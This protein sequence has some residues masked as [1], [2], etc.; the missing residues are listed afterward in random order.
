MYME[1]REIIKASKPSSTDISSY[2][3]QQK[4][5]WALVV[6]ELQPYIN[7]GLD[8][9]L[10]T[11]EKIREAIPLNKD[12]EYEFNLDLR[13]VGNEHRNKAYQQLEKFL[14]IKMYLF[15]G[16]DREQTFNI[17]SSIQR[18][19]EYVKVTM[20]LKSLRW[21]LDFGKKQ[22]FVSF[23]KPSFLKL[24][25]GY[26]MNLFLLLSENYNRGSF[27]VSIDEIKKRLGCPESYD[28]D[29][30]KTK[31]LIPAFKEYKE[32]GSVIT[33][34]ARFYSQDDK[35]SSSGRKR[36]NMIEFTVFR[37]EGDK[38]IQSNN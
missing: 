4:R 22:M 26:S 30:V 6:E 13:I 21:F 16:E 18:E 8:W 34:D 19:G 24:T 31:V 27:T 32:K 28:A 2:T 7:R 29:K 36:L 5:G 3:V 25:T 12:C 38:W 1:D 9:D 35:P 17:F 10:M 20:G 11:A 37:K 14:D 33:F 15:E 23:H